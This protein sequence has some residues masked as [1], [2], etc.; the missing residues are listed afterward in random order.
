M[1]IF[2][3][4]RKWGC[5]EKYP[6][7]NPIPC[8]Q[9]LQVPVSQWPGAAN[10]GQRQQGPGGQGAGCQHFQAAWGKKWLFSITWSD[11]EYF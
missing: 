6:E 1:N 7:C 10:T 9:G 3:V 11:F 8:W 5:S 2:K 4:S